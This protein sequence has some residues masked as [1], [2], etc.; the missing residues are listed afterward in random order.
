MRFG[1]LAPVLAG[2]LAAMPLA[3]QPPAAGAR[4]GQAWVT[5]ALIM[6]L[7][8]E[9]AVR[10]GT[11]RMAGH[12]TAAWANWRRIRDMPPGFGA[13]PLRHESFVL[14]DVGP[15]GEATGCRPLR[16]SSEPRL[17]AFAC[18]LLMRPGYFEANLVPPATPRRPERWVMG[19]S[20]ETMDAASFAAREARRPRSGIAPAAPRAA[21]APRPATPPRPP[22]PPSTGPRHALGGHITAADYAGIK[23]LALANGDFLAELSVDAEG[24]VSDCRVANSTGNAAVDERSCAILRRVRYSLRVDEAGNPIADRVSQ[25][26]DLGWVLHGTTP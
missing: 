1:F 8:D 7:E 14:L 6:R 9:F 15:A 4:P 22:P 3:A 20:F 21:P 5:E 13:R 12:R 19:L 11:A 16:A 23:D 26:I 25:P 24:R 17:D 10:P 2:L 18:A